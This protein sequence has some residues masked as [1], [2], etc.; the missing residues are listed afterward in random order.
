MF[1]QTLNKDH[2]NNII[3]DKNIISDILSSNQVSVNIKNR[4]SRS[5]GS[6]S[7][8]IQIFKLNAEDTLKKTDNLNNFNQIMDI[9]NN[10]DKQNNIIN[11]ENNKLN[12]SLTFNKS[13]DSKN[14]THKHSSSSY[15]HTSHISLSE[16]ISKIENKLNNLNAKV[17]SSQILSVNLDSRV[18]SVTDG[19]EL[20]ESKIIKSKS[21][22]SQ[23]I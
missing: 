6:N 7:Q 12:K 10:N 1:S 4:Y 2:N 5:N 8:S 18:K 9:K 16:R 20:V 3:I 14:V 11:P 17:N 15:L 23:N 21:F 13:K 19:S 22:L